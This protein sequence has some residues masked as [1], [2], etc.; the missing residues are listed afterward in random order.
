MWLNLNGF[1]KLPWV[2]RDPEML[3]DSG[4]EDMGVS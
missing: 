2:F 3:D 1:S 4:G